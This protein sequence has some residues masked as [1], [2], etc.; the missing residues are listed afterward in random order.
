MPKQY[1]STE[2]LEDFAEHEPYCNVRQILT[3]KC[4]DHNFGYSIK[5]AVVDCCAD[6]AVL[7]GAC[8]MMRD[9]YE[10]GTTGCLGA[11]KQAKYYHDYMMKVIL[12]GSE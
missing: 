4:R 7:E 9:W 1:Y 3:T 8:E 11:D 5:D 12:E 10:N 6:D 2:L